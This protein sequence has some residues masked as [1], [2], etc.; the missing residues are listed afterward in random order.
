MPYSIALLNSSIN[1]KIVCRLPSIH[2]PN[3]IWFI[4]LNQMHIKATVHRTQNASM[5]LLQLFQI[6]SKENAL[7]THSLN[8]LLENARK[9]TILTCL[10]HP[11]SSGV[12]KYVDY[13]SRQCRHFIECRDEYET[14]AFYKL[15]YQ[16]VY[17][18]PGTLYS[19]ECSRQYVCRRN[20]TL[21]IAYNCRYFSCE[22]IINTKSLR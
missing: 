11:C 6:F 10:K 9:T 7:Q 16:I 17:C 5:I 15:V 20:Q 18:P 19:P 1:L 8:H 21:S 13:E 4:H 2:V 14:M 12:G 3:T 22:Q